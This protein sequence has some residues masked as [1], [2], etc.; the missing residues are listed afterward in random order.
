MSKSAA[1]ML[2]WMLKLLVKFSMFHTC[3]LGYFGRVH[4]KK[5]VGPVS[6]LGVFNRRLLCPSVK[7]GILCYSSDNNSIQ[8]SHAS[9]SSHHYAVCTHGLPTNVC[10]SICFWHSTL[11]H[12]ELG[13]LQTAQAT[14]PQ[15]CLE[16]TEAVLLP[17]CHDRPGKCSMQEVV[18]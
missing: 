3:L 10:Q 14:G 12:K 9:V 6:L 15:S 16:R 1:Q 11:H 2:C 13:P 5:P 8:H 7:Y 18:N 17:R 4:A